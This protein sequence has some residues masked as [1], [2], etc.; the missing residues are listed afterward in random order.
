MK[1]ITTIL[2]FLICLTKTG[3]AQTEDPKKG[4]KES[5]NRFYYFE[6]PSSLN[7]SNLDPSPISNINANFTDSKISAK[8]GFPALF[9]DEAAG[10]NLS[11]TGFLQL[12]A[13]ASNGLSTLYKSGN[14]PSELGAS[15][16]L[17]F[18]LHQ[19]FWVYKGTEI[20]SSQRVVWLNV[21]GS[22][23]RANY[24]IFSPD[25]K[26]GGL[27]RRETETN[28][29]AF[30]SLNYYFHSEITRYWWKRC[31]ASIGLGYAKAN[32]YASLKKR[33]LDDGKLVYNADSSAYQS[34][35]ETTAGAI[36]EL[37]IAK[38]FAGFAELFIPIIKGKQSKK[39]GSLY[40]GNRLT[41][42]GIGNKKEI[43][44]GNTG[45]YI[46]L[47]DKKLDA[48]SPDKPAK[49]VI[50]FSLT[51]QFNKLNDSGK[52]GYLKDNFSVQVQLAVPLRFN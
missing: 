47:K 48:T 49:D 27:I 29:S 51:G 13:K 36:G 9:S 40:F 1:K 42:Y 37:T 5:T 28:G 15:A 16:G 4:T 33:T 34:V 19:N 52:D 31:I 44:N 18:I 11:T 17:S 2:I 21:L 23:E 46:T 41:Y 38:G 39:Y 3:I 32:D 10:R 7:G 20:H 25:E 24:N 8:L 35:V 50:S 45:F 43:I 14:P 26:Y 12:N 30:L 22:I 6:I